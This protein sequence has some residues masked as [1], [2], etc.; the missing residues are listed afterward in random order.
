MRR[1][2]HAAFL[3]PVALWLLAGC[4]AAKIQLGADYS[5]ALRESTLEG[6]GA[7]KVVLI[8][9]RGFISSEPKGDALGYKPSTVQEV[10]SHLE[11]AAKDPKV[12]A[13]VLELDTPGGSV[14]ASDILYREI[15]AFKQRTRV[16]VV[17]AMMDLAT[18]GGY[19]VALASDR[20]VAHPTCVTGSIGVIFIRP[21]IAGLMDKLGV[22]AEVTKS[23][24]FKDMGSPFRDS[25]GAER[26]IFQHIIDDL[27]NRFVTLVAEQRHLDPGTART[28]AD[29]R[30]YTAQQALEFKL[31]DRIGYLPDAFAEAKK[32][33]GL[34]DDTRVV[35]YRRTRFRNDNLYNTFTGSG[36][37]NLPKM[38]DLGWSR[39][40]NVPST[41]FYYLWAPEFS[42]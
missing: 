36:S 4:I 23:G 10:V 17:S 9:I 19:Y 15:D 29:G 38:F 5:E 34:P 25:T 28:L 13:V 41:G 20:I 35:V 32:L 27:N 12:K 33:A 14:T 8:P 11:L 2:I 21:Q 18:S 3:F 26:Q 7:P 16:K 24:Q 37:G 42:Q 40:L 30:I 22:A 6:K 39:V 1:L 31:I